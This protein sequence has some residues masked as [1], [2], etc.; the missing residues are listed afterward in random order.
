MPVE[1]NG[2]TLHQRWDFP[3]S[4]QLGRQ[5]ESFA[6]APCLSSRQRRQ[7]NGQFTIGL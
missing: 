2:R 7:K 4:R 3:D 1:Q 5:Y 6:I